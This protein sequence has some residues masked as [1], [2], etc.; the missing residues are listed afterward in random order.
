MRRVTLYDG[1]NSYVGWDQAQ[2]L[3]RLTGLGHDEVVAFRIRRLVLHRCLI[4]VTAE[5]HVPDGPRYADLGI[6]LRSMASSIQTGEVAG[7]LPAAEAAFEALRAATL[8]GV[9]AELNRPFQ[10]GP[11]TPEPAGFWG[12]LLGRDGGQA[13]SA[14]PDFAALI[15]EWQGRLDDADRD[16][17][18]RLAALIRVV[19]AVLARR[20]D[21]RPA[22]IGWL[23]DTVTNLASN[24]LGDHLVETMI[25]PLID[26]AIDRLRYRR[27]PA[28]AEPVVL[29]AKGAS[30]SGKSSIRGAQHQIADK[31]SIDWHDFAVI[32]PDY[33]RKSLIDYQGLGED[34]KYGAMLCGQELEIIDKKLDRLMAE[35]GARSAI[36]H[37][38]IDRFRFDSFHAA[39]ARPAD[40]SLLTRFGARIFMFF[41]IT[42]PEETVKRAWSRG[43]E[44]GRYKAVDDLLYHNIEAYTGMPDLFFSWAT[45]KD[46]WVHYEFLDNAVPKGSLP[47]TV[48]FGANGCLVISDLDIFCNMERYKHVNVDAH[49]PQDILEKP[50]DDFA[51]MAPARRAC[52]ELETVIFLK[53]GSDH[54]FAECR[55]G[56]LTIDHAALPD[57]RSADLFGPHEPADKPFDAL[58]AA[59]WSNTIGINGLKNQV[60]SSKTPR[61]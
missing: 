59:K 23:A 6:N 4:R 28:Q 11:A 21:I 33:W 27:L 38:V 7:A 53:P 13:A 18:A 8:A 31:L 44:T 5:L 22:D 54:P 46:R 32:S 2:E 1:A 12:R 43:V 51:A 10:A 15:K 9:S 52:K 36:P 61:T 47:R 55:D 19:G 48:A 45:V 30:A 50:L 16:E 17:R 40:S 42:P 60:K 3:I 25:D 35:H 20:G 56:V 41:M 37:L 14:P 29:N 34:F 39:H 58:P 26:T 57:D 24:A 49:R